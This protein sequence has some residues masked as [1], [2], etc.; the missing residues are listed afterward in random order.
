MVK[1]KPGALPES[2]RPYAPGA[3][4][5]TG[6][7][8]ALAALGVTILKVPDGKVPQVVADLK[9]SPVVEFAEP[10]YLVH[11]AVITPSDPGWANQYGPVRI[12]A[13]QAW[14]ITIGSSSVTIA[15]IDSGVD[16]DHPD[17]ASKIW[18]NPGET[19]GG[20]QTNG[21]DDD[22]DGYVDGRT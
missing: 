9:R 13:P 1:L 19:G 16:L 18:T 15:V 12:Q 21:V 22:G 14:D 5:Q 6:A 10:N 3:Q 20:K 17:L 8:V 7:T 4:V 11:T 2:F